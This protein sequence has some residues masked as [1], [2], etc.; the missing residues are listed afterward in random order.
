MSGFV[1]DKGIWRPDGWTPPAQPAG[2]AKPRGS[3]SRRKRAA[4]VRRWTLFNRFM[5]TGLV[6]VRHADAS[7]WLTLFR[8]AGPDGV[9]TVSRTRLARL[10]GADPKT[11]TG[12]LTRLE[13]V[14]W[15]TRLK[16]GGPSGGIAVY[17]VHAPP[18][19]AR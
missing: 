4:Q 5:D 14:G 7:V 6:D 18:R 8:H 13:E 19:R 2:K 15:L 1:D 9:A 11:V 10:V 17:R 3:R 12:A 16:R